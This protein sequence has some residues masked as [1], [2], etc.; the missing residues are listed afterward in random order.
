MATFA[1]HTGRS[2]TLVFEARNPGQCGESIPTEL[3]EQLI[4]SL[5][6]M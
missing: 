5:R 6:F 3:Y 1:V 4:Q 2:Y